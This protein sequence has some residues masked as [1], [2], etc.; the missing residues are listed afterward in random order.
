MVEEA[1]WK[2]AT[3]QSE[4]GPGVRRRQRAIV[5]QLREQKAHL[6]RLRETQN[7][8]AQQ[9][10]LMLLQLQHLLATTS[11]LSGYGSK[12]Y[13]TMPRGHSPNPAS[14]RLT[15]RLMEMLSSSSSDAPDDVT[16]SLLM[17]GRDS[18]SSSPSES[19]GRE[20]RRCHSD[21]RLKIISGRHHEKRWTAEIEALQQQIL[22]EDKEI[23]RLKSKSPYDVHEKDSVKLKRK[24]DFITKRSRDKKEKNSGSVSPLSVLVHGSRAP[25]DDSLP[26]ENIFAATHD[27]QSSIPEEGGSETVSHSDAASSISEQEGLTSA[28]HRTGNSKSKESSHSKRVPS[29]GV[30]ER[31]TR[32]THTSKPKMIFRELKSE[33]VRENISDSNAMET[34]SPAKTI[35]SGETTIEE[36]YSHDNSDRI[37]KSSED[38]NVVESEVCDKTSKSQES[39]IRTKLST[40]ES[41]KSAWKKPESVIPEDITDNSKTRTPSNSSWHRIN[42]RTDSVESSNNTKST[43]GKPFSQKS[44]TR[45]LPLPLKVPLSPRSLHRQHRRYSSESDDSFTLSQTETASDVSDGEGKLLALK[46]ELAVR[47]AEAERLKKEKRRLRRERLASQER[48]LKQQISTYDAYIQHA[49]ME[50]EKESKELQQVSM[51]RPLIKK[52]QV[53]ETK[54]SRLSESVTSPEKSD[55]SDASL[56][57]ESSRSDQSS[58]SKLQETGLKERGH[59][60]PQEI[61]KMQELHLKE[62]GETSLQIHDGISYSS[63]KDGETEEKLSSSKEVT[64]SEIAKSQTE[65][66]SE[67]TSCSS[68]ISENLNEESGSEYLEDDSCKKSLSQ[69]SS[70]ESDHTN[71]Q[72]SSTETIVHSPQKLDPSQK[73]EGGVSV[74]EVNAALLEVLKD[75]EEDLPAIVSIAGTSDAKTRVEGEKLEIFIPTS[76]S[77]FSEAE[78]MVEGNTNT[79][80]EQSICEEVFDDNLK[81]TENENSS[82]DTESQNFLHLVTME[83]KIHQETVESNFTSENK[84]FPLEYEVAPETNNSATLACEAKE[85]PLGAESKIHPATLDRQRIVDDISN[86]LL[87]VMMKD[88]SQLFTNIIQDKVNIT[89]ASEVMHHAEAFK[90][91]I[92]SKLRGEALV[93]QEDVGLQGPK[94]SCFTAPEEET[95]G[96]KQESSSKSQILQRVNEL[97]GESGSGSPRLTSLSSPRSGDVQLAFDL[98]PESSPSATPAIGQLHG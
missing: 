35:S 12:G 37:S 11:N 61:I 42:T 27:S 10:R 90:E 39:S 4:G 64:L 7:I 26:A 28:S 80:E 3:L 89:K 82:Q 88:T 40:S 81:E 77:K 91:S 18:D 23:L 5:L 45:G 17:R 98:T 75:N 69:E 97:I 71:S 70:A 56:V 33:D 86:N 96:S 31:E 60:K 65:N 22:H 46:E 44:S 73:E 63:S 85:I 43:E 93:A 2:L 52:P 68:S 13:L 72:A 16:F 94:P 59:V 41:V 15:P 55:V 32:E 53:A 19:G 92:V 74:T 20:K 49:R 66:E 76:G 62:I 21:D 8:G 78:E 30:K 84:Q 95:S 24:G 38:S 83:D 51:V 1:K 48:A 57:S 87:A 50:L 36:R 47:R 6:K 14:P 34:S 79:S 9:R 25:V 58:T 54:K 67:K 29:Y